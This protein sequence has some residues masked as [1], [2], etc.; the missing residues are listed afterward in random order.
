MKVITYNDDN[1]SIEDIEDKI[2]KARAVMIN[3]NG[4]IYISLYSGT[5]LFP[6]GKI[7]AFENIS[8]GAQR[9]V[10]EETGIEL[11]L[12]NQE[13]FLLVQQFIKKYPKRD[14]TND[15]SNRLNETYYYLVHTNKDIDSAKMELMENELSNNFHTI[16]AGA[17]EILLLLKNNINDSYR[18][19]YY[20]REAQ[21]VICE[22]QK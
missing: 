4:Q 10:K 2:T 20:S 3:D 19:K 12:S 9:E 8:Q 14:T 11:D 16:Q 18:N 7:E 13:P 21:A 5:Y 1:L 17:D 15:L 6:G 22:L